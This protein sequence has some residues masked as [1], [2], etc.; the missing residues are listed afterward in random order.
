MKLTYLLTLTLGFGSVLT[1][2][3][4]VTGDKPVNPKNELVTQERPYSYD[5]AMSELAR[6][7][8]MVFNLDPSYDYVK[9]I[10][11]PEIEAK[12]AEIAPHFPSRTVTGDDQ[13]LAKQQFELWL[14]NHPAEFRAYIDYVDNYVATYIK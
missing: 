13:E 10:I 6:V 7:H 3:A 14:T 9:G 4:S 1:T 5:Y 8:K 12:R 11:M 2:S